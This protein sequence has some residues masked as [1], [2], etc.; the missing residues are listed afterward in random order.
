MPLLT[1]APYYLIMSSSKPSLIALTLGHGSNSFSVQLLKFPATDA[2]LLEKVQAFAY[3]EEV[4]QQFHS[5]L[6]SATLQQAYAMPIQSAPLQPPP[7]NQITS[8]SC[9]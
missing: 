7:K 3:F 9:F 2:P 1:F 8:D 4:I 6:S 5:Q